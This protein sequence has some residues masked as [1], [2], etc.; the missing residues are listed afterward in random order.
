M[1]KSAQPAMACGRKDMSFFLLEG[2]EDSN[3]YTC[4]YIYTYICMF[5]YLDLI[6]ISYE[7]LTF[8]QCLMA[9]MELSKEAV[10]SCRATPFPQLG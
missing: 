10:Q 1:R 8:K 7:W 4:I 9:S 2:D 6:R 5:T 3:T